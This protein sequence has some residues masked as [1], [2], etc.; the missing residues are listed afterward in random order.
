MTKL[1][2]D[3]PDNTYTN[4]NSLIIYFKDCNMKC[5]YCDYKKMFKLKNLKEVNVNDIEKFIV[6]NL[7]FIDEIIITGGEPTT[8]VYTLR[9]LINLVS[10][11]ELKC[12]LY[13]NLLELPDSI[14]KDVDR[15]VVDVKGGDREEIMNNTDIS[16][17]ESRILI[18]KYNIYKNSKKFLWRVPKDLSI[19]IDFKNV[20][21]Y[22]KELI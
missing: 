15:I 12:I 4:K 13:S 19:D 14:I 8:D 21:Y 17:K 2:M 3:F 5:K 16:Y 20:E 10:E 1:L 7:A 22:D 11:Y 9:K 6:G 18:F